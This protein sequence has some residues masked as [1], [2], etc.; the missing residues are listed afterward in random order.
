MYADYFG[1]REPPFSIAPDPRFFYFNSINQEASASL[2]YGIKAKKGFIVVTGEVGTG[3]T[4]LL[5]RVMRNLEV[6]IQSVFIFNTQLNFIELL[7]LIL[8]D[9]GLSSDGKSKVNMIQ[10]FNDYLIEQ[11]KKSGTVA[12][13]IDEAQN[14]SNQALEGLRLLSNLETDREKL[15][16][17][18]LMGQPELD[19]KLNNPSL[20]QL[21]QRI[22][23][24]CSLNALMPKEIESYIKHRLQIAGYNGPEIFS[25]AAVESLWTYSRGI[26]R[27]IN[28]LCDSALLICFASNKRVV[29]SAMIDEVA[30]D[31]KLEPESGPASKGTQDVR[32]EK[33]Q[34]RI[35]SIFHLGTDEKATEI[36]AAKVQRSEAKVQPSG[37]D[38]ARRPAASAPRG[39]SSGLRTV[40]A[41]IAPQRFMDTIARELIQATGP[42][43][44]RVLRDQIANFGESFDAFPKSRLRELI[45]TVSCEI[46]HDQLRK[47]FEQTMLR[48]MNAYSAVKTTS[49]REAKWLK[50]RR[51]SG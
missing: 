25:R 49:Q 42:M 13:F 34:P 47:Q 43:G 46:L 45:D 31:L 26:P 9:L 48:E 11:L 18:V 24:R 50:S 8:H 33:A 7:Q 3:K 41:E 5:R 29:S 1:F 19:V 22:A 28:S 21:K 32:A 23:L 4:T 27:L 37:E 35:G 15:L 16:Q 2:L 17:I 40:Q 30:R 36:P 39:T 20:R 51:A 12:L 14:L 10:E 38:R 44:P 6:P